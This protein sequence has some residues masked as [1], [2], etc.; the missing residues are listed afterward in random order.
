VELT[1]EPGEVVAL[2]GPSGGGK[3]TL[4][5]LLARLLLPEAGELRLDG[6][7][8]AAV[9]TRLWRRRVGLLF[10]T[11][12]MLPGTVAEN[13][14]AAGRFG[15]PVPAERVPTWL[16]QVG[17]APELAERPAARLSLGQQQRVALARLLAMGPR[18]LLLDEPTA[19][20]DPDSTG[21]VAA[22]LERLREGGLGILLVSHEMELVRR[23]ADRAL[24]L[25][26]GR[27]AAAGAVEEV[28][29]AAPEADA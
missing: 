29:A 17:L 3:T 10:Q 23:L 14:R 2:V 6:E 16:A 19:A 25:R 18:Y 12:H 28:L 11:P 5:R 22:L 13:V 9:D 24:L 21:S 20:L 26:A 8:A 27:V 4:V 1:L 15:E 7:A